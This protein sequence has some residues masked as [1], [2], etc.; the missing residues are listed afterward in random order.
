MRPV[1]G[2]ITC[3]TILKG[4]KCSLHCDAGYGFAI[5]PPKAYYCDFE[6]GKWSPSAKYPFP[7]CSG[8]NL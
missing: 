8:M 1:N 5:H 4:L 2:G 6:T 7:D 3:T